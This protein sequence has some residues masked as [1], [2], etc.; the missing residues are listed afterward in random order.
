[1]TDDTA[2]T[3]EERLEALRGLLS[4]TRSDSRAARNMARTETG[5]VLFGAMLHAADRLRQG[6]PA[7]DL[8]EQL[9]E[10]L[11]AG[12]SEEEIKDWGRVYREAV[13]A[14]GGRLQGVSEAVTGRPVSEGYSLAEW[15]QDAGALGEECRARSNVSV[16]DR[17]ALAAGGAFD[18]PE[19]IEGMREWG[20][21][22]TVPAS[23]SQYSDGHG[24][25]ATFAG[26][27]AAP[28]I[29][30]AT[31]ITSPYVQAAA[32]GA[33]LREKR[34]KSVTRPATG[35]YCVKVDAGVD[36]ANSIV[37]VELYD[38]Y[39]RTVRITPTSQCGNA[40]NTI[41]VLMWTHDGTA[42][43]DARFTAAVL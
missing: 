6:E 19:F 17:G 26:V 34:I 10:V 14:R 27:L 43:T 37:Q 8:Q 36:V 5:G 29:A 24:A 40:A 39:R 2:R 42:A 13:T 22:V 15:V 16:I 25:A 21:G 33:L 12:L 38:A 35:Q 3:P 23:A 20:F 30:S 4:G 7:T 9:L 31:P 41:T 1:M 32:D 11:R 18:S 28:A